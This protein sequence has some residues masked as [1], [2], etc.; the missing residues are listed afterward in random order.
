MRR[1]AS[2]CWRG[3]RQ[4]A[5]VAIVAEPHEPAHTIEHAHDWQSAAR[6][7]DP[8]EVEK[9]PDRNPARAIGKVLGRA[10]AG[11]DAR[12]IEQ[13]RREHG[14]GRGRLVEP[15]EHGR[16]L[17]ERLATGIANARDRIGTLKPVAQRLLGR[18]QMFEGRRHVR[19]GQGE[20]GP[21]GDSH[22]AHGAPID[23]DRKES[24]EILDL[25]P[26]E[27][28]A[29]EEDRHAQPFKACAIVD[30]F[31]LPVQSTAWS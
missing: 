13:Q 29:Q 14:P 27:Q 6:R 7:L 1:T 2:R 4:L 15:A 26:L 23:E 5:Q 21:A 30:S 17:G 9:L 24:Q 18:P 20:V 10:Q 11:G 25:T 19:E 31:S 16:E 12:A 8:Q 22:Q 28:T 3:R